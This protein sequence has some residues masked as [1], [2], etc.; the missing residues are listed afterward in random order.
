ML[1]AQVEKQVECIFPAKRILCGA[2]MP[3]RI[4]WKLDPD[5]WRSPLMVLG[6]QRHIPFDVIGGATAYPTELLEA[7]AEFRFGGW[8]WWRWAILP[9]I[10]PYFVTGAIIASGGAWNGSI[11][12]EAVEGFARIER[13]DTKP[14]RGET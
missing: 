10:S 13:S 9:G 11:V 5:I 12:A 4:Q 6:T 1:S 2:L 8:Q 14:A 7:A 3:V